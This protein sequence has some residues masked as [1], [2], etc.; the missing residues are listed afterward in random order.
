MREPK[1]AALSIEGVVFAIQGDTNPLS[2]RTGLGSRHS[3]RAV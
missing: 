1:P 3:R 2:R